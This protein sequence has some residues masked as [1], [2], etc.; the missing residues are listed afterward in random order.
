MTK[1]GKPSSLLLTSARVG[2]DRGLHST[3]PIPHGANSVL[4]VDYTG[5]PKFEGYNFALVVTCGL[6]R[7]TKVF[8]CSKHITGEET[9]PVVLCVWGT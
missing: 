3:V 7:F 1:Y 2:T 5:M 4:Y 9:S 6:T 8:P